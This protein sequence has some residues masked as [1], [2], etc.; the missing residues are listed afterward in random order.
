MTEEPYPGK[1]EQGGM[2][3]APR[4]IFQATAINHLS[5]GVRDYAVTRDWYMDIFGMECVYDD[6]SQASVV[7]GRPRREIYI[8]KREKPP[9]PCI[10]HWAFSISGFEAERV[11]R[12]LVSR[13]IEGVDWDGDFALHARDDNGFLTQICAEAGVFPGAATR[14]WNTA[15]KV[16][17]G[18]K[19]ARPSRTGWRATA[20]HPVSYRVP[21]YERTRDFYATLF[22]MRVLF[23]DGSK[24][25][26][27]F[28][29][30]PQDSISLAGSAD[31]PAID[32]I[33]VAVAGFDL[34][35]AEQTIR[36]LGLDYAAA[37]ESAWT[38]IDPDGQPVQVCA[39]TGVSPR[40]PGDFIP[41]TGTE[42]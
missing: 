9:V 21:D 40:A 37:G 39:E 8:R 5:Y 13:G 1:G 38:L 29:T 18:E 41:R 24:C 6:G 11:R 3:L 28:G 35:Q 34:Q 36:R 10:D 42:K 7:F 23:D 26:L 4:G 16:P 27:S 32:H 12:T 31:G 2:G 22:G 15:G 19:A 17:S 30:A 20:L 25:V 33:A 14:G